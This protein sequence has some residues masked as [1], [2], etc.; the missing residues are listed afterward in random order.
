MTSQIGRSMLLVLSLVLGACP[1]GGPEK[2]DLVPAKRSGAEGPQG[3]CQRDDNNLTVRVRNQANPD[4][5][6]QTAVR[7]DF[8]SFG[9]Q[10]ATAAAIPGGSFADVSVPIPAGCFNADCEF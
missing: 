5:V 4:V 2:A 6:Q 7:V 9:T 3:F 1:G 10:T 8:G